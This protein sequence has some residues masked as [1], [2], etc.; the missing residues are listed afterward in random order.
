MV[1]APSLTS[2]VL[3]KSWVEV[4]VVEGRGLWVGVGVAGHQADQGA[5]EACLPGRMEVE[6]G[7]G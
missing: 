3:V 4:V 5:M 7:E 6:E 1:A 2:L